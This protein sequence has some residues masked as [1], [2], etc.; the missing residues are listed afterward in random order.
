MLT[1]DISRGGFSL[2]PRGKVLRVEETRGILG[3]TC[4]LRVCS[5]PADLGETS[6]QNTPKEEGEPSIVLGKDPPSSSWQSPWQAGE[7]GA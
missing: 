2:G 4:P 3:D 7:L 5:M 6:G 1:S